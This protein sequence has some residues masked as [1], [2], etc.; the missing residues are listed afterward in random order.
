METLAG[1][2]FSEGTTTI[3]WIVT[4]IAGNQTS[5]SFE[6][7]VNTFVGIESIQDAGIFIYPNPTKGIINIDFANT[8]TSLSTSNIQK[9]IITD[10]TG[11]Q[12]FEKTQL[13]QNEAIDLTNF[14]SVIY[15]ISIQTKDKV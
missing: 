3:V 15:I 11:K 1:A 2:I 6:A 14:E 8:S 10:I 5:C 7:L 13:Q 9:L 4:D 12:I